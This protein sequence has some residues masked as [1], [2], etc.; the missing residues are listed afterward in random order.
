MKETIKAIGK[1]VLAV[2]VAGGIS[3]SVSQTVQ[4]LG[5][6][7]TKSIH[8]VQDKI[9]PVEVVSKRKVTVGN[10]T[11]KGFSKC[12]KFLNERDTKRTQ[13]DEKVEKNVKVASYVIGGAAGVASFKPLMKVMNGTI[14]NDEELADICDEEI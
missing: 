2:T 6:V 5:K 7:T 9:T 14:I 13:F 10:Q 4:G 8:F 1:S 11:I 12:K 3:T